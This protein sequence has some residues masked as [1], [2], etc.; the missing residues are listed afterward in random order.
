VGS[1]G[2]GQLVGEISVA[3]GE[4]ATAT[5]VTMETVHYL[6]IERTALQKLRK[7]DPSIWQALDHCVR[8][9]L[10]DKLVQMNV[11]ASAQA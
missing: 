4:P 1:C 10:Q 7:S 11:S 2:A 6:A 3:A 8:R 5:A 9:N